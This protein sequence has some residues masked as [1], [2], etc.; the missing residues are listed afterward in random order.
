[1]PQVESGRIVETATQARGAVRGVPVLYMLV[2]G[3]AA[4]VALFAVI[5]IYFF[6]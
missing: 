4:V 6:A 2:S 5:Y 3:T 1:M